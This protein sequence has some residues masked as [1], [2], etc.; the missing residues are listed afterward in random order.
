VFG[1]PVYTSLDR[2]EDIALP[3]RFDALRGGQTVMAVGYDDKRR[4]RSDKGAILIRNSWGPDWGDAG[5][6]WLP[7]SYIQRKIA[8][9][10]W[11]VLT[12]A[13]ISSDEFY[14]MS[15]A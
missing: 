2:S 13:W 4:I 12:P 3:T 14:R 7:Y 15:L 10:F 1:F 5:Y 9:D 8:H 11:T 6:G